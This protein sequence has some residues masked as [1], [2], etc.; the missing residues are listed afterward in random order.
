MIGAEPVDAFL[1]KC[2][3]CVKGQVTAAGGPE[4]LTKYTAL[5]AALKSR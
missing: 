3:T 4:I 5:H 1:V 2:A